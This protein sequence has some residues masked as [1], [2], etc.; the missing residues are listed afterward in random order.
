MAKALVRSR[1]DTLGDRL[2]GLV[3]ELRKM[4]CPKCY[5]N[6]VEAQCDSRTGVMLYCVG[7]DEF[8]SDEGMCTF[9]S[10]HTTTTLKD[11]PS[12]QEK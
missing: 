2:A 1:M 3:L 9:K 10:F 7:W 5:Q 4:E 11:M 12:L 6:T 8:G